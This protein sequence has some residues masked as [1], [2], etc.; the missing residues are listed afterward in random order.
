MESAHLSTDAAHR[1]RYAEQLR[2]LRRFFPSDRI[3]VLRYERCAEDPTGEL[4]RTYRFLGLEDQQAQTYLDVSSPRGTPGG[5]AKLPLPDVVRDALI[6]YLEDDVR[7]LAEIASELDVGA[8]PTFA[9][10]VGARAAPS[11][12]DERC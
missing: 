7:E 11:W 2:R 6:A 3:L 10:S 1:G 9:H 12:V 5:D 8:W 4:R